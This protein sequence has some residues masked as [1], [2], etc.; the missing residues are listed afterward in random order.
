[1]G[2]NNF[3]LSTCPTRKKKKLAWKVHCPQSKWKLKHWSGQSTLHT[4]HGSETMEAPQNRRFY[5]TMKCL[6]LWPTYID[7]KGED[8]W[9]KHMG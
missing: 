1:M 9:A 5:R 7:E 8:F 4:E 2:T 3:K 6:P